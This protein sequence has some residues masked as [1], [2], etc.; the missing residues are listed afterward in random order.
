MILYETLPERKSLEALNPLL[1]ILLY[2]YLFRACFT[3]TLSDTS[4]WSD[5]RCNS[6][7]TEESN[8]KVTLRV[9]LD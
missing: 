1:P 9:F 2:L 7:N 4:R 6:S 8:L 5:S 3:K